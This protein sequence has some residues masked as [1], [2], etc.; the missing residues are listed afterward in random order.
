MAWRIIGETFST[1]NLLRLVLGDATYLLGTGPQSEVAV[2]AGGAHASKATVFGHQ[3]MDPKLGVVEFDDNR[4]TA[5][6]R[7][8]NKSRSQTGW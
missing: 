6:V 1:V 3:V 4:A 7:K 2:I 8:Q 5:A